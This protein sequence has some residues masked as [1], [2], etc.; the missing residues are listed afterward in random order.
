MKTDLPKGFKDYTGEQAEKREFIKEVLKQTFERYGF[1]PAETPVVEYEEFV[2]G[3]NPN[4]EAVSDIFKLEDRGKRKLALRY[5]HTFSLKR[6]MQNK[7]IPYK[8]YAIGPVFRDEPVTGNRTRQFTQC[9][10]DILGSTL[11]DDAEILAVI[12]SVLKALQIEATIFVNN[13]RIMNEIFETQGIVTNKD[14]IIREIDKLDK[15][16]EKE[17]KENLK[18][19]KAENILD[20]FKK[21]IKEFEQYESFKEVKEL[22]DYCKAYGVKIEFQPTLARGLSYYTG[23]VFEI[24]TKQI[25]E[26]IFGGGS[27]TFNGVQGVGFGVSLERLGIVTNIRI[28]LEKY[29]IVSLNQDK[30][31]IKIANQFREAGKNV[32]MY[33]GKPSKALEYANSY[34][35]N[36]VI[37]IGEEEVKLKQFKVR[38]MSSGKESVLRF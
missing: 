22:L 26:T 4:D 37:F 14:Q 6:V 27:Y 21:P 15:L 32:S 30:Q 5:E 35:I 36:K 2:R 13:R 11:K 25:R 10:I 33:Y 19:F 38:I 9:D 20:I 16:S 24:K 28:D 23:T 8:R 7:K 17:V 3:E 34:G 18:K 12:N 1:Q 29:L 31:A